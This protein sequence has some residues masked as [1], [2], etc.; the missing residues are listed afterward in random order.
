MLSRVALIPRGAKRPDLGGAFLDFLLSPDVRERL[1]N[2]DHFRA[3]STITS[4]PI[5]LNPTL[6]VFLDPMK[7]ARFIKVWKVLIGATF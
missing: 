3:S 4:H 6:L 1:T 2:L 5:P 7:R